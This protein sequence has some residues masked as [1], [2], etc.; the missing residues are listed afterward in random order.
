MSHILYKSESYQIIG[1]CMKIHTHMGFGFL[2]SVYAE[3]LEKSLCA[4]ISLMKEK[5]S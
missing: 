1:V 5:R 2:E 3:I 4:Y